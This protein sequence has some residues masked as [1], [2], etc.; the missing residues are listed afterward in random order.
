MSEE[1][2]VTRGLDREIDDLVDLVDHNTPEVMFEKF[3]AA[4]MRLHEEFGPEHTTLPEVSFMLTL[5]CIQIVSD[6]KEVLG[7]HG[8]HK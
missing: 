4:A 3:A 6:T 2:P 8:K 1:Y 7:T 5:R